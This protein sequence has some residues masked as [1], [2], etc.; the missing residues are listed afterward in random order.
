MLRSWVDMEEKINRFSVR[1]GRN[2]LDTKKEP[3]VWF[4]GIRGLL[5][6]FFYKQQAISCCFLI[7]Y[8]SYYHTYSLYLPLTYSYII[9][10]RFLCSKKLTIAYKQQRQVGSLVHILC[11]NKSVVVIVIL[12]VAISRVIGQYFSPQNA[13]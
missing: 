12:S 2:Q 9:C 4:C 7:T 13:Q 8:H 1:S 3:N 10:V 11:V 6:V 5:N